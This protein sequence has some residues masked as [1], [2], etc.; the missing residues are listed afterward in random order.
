[1]L[2]TEYI[3]PD[4]KSELKIN[5]EKL[6]LGKNASDIEIDNKL[7]ELEDDCINLL[8]SYGINY[9]LVFD[10]VD[11]LNGYEDLLKDM[12]KYNISKYIVESGNLVVRNEKANKI[13]GL[14]LHDKFLN[15]FTSFLK[16]LKSIELDDEGNSELSK[17]IFGIAEGN[18]RLGLGIGYGNRYGYR[19][20]GG[21]Y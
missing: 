9:N 10:S 2:E 5:G 16:L 14:S 13:Y 7:K 15:R 21:R 4:V 6:R 8:N 12:L 17:S 18:T 1:M 11:L 20:I 3:Y 19:F